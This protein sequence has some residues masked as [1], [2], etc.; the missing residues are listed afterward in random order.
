MSSAPCPSPVTGIDHVGIRV[1]D[2]ERSIAF[3]E[4][5]GF[6]QTAYFRDRQANEM[7]TAAGV[8]INLISNGAPAHMAEVMQWLSVA[9]SEVQN[10]PADDRRLRRAALR[11]AGARRRGLARAVPVDP[12]LDRA[13]EVAAELLVDAGGL[14]RSAAPMLSRPGAATSKLRAPRLRAPRPPAPSSLRSSP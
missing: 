13:H 5:L 10:K 4:R 2:R 14:R 12:G 9:A 1:S 8:R 11:G 7:E 3:Y 6:V